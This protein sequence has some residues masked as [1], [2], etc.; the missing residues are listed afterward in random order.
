MQKAVFFDRDGI[1]NKII[2]RSDGY[3]SSPRKFEEFVFIDGIK[4]LMEKLKEDNFLNIIITSQPEIYRGLLKIEELE[5]IHS[6]MNEILPI[7][8]IFVCLHDDCHNCDCRKPK[9]GMLIEAMKKWDIDLS[10]SFMVGDSPKDIEVGR[11]VGCKTILLE[12]QY[13]INKKIH[14]HFKVQSIL[15]IF[16]IINANSD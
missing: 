3:V 4:E 2:V 7:D 1:I 10:K 12:T 8:D 9:P 15:D 6:H 16:N 14:P 13:N 11:N 5:R